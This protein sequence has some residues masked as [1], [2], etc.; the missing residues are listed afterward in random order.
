MQEP[1]HWSDDWASTYEWT[2][3]GAS[4][5]PIFGTSHVP[6]AELGRP[7]G[8]LL[9]C[10]GFKGYKDYGLIPQLAEGAAQ[11]GLIAHR[12]NF[13]HSGVTREYKTFKRPDLF[14]A[15]TWFKQVYDLR[16]VANAVARDELPGMALPMVWFG[17]SR[18]GVTAL[19]ANVRASVGA[20]PVGLVTAATPNQAMNLDE[21]DQRTLREEGRLAAPS[22]RTGQTLYIGKRWLQEIESDPDAHD[23]ELAIAAA[24]VPVLIV[25]GTA[26]ETVPVRAANRL[27]RACPQWSELHLI[28]GAGHT[29]DAKNPLPLSETPPAATREL[30]DATC[31]FT[32]RVCRPHLP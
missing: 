26:D 25:H 16:A 11:H 6:P 18:G 24:D 14:Q 21:A 13:S 27:H 28:E 32:L 23:P 10:H 17:H 30:I 31:Q 8:V 15:D 4:G 1:A 12:F 5:E 2:I 3:E 29:F 19:L 20:R 7:Q 9:I 22:A